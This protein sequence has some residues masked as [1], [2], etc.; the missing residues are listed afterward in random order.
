MDLLISEATC[1]WQESTHLN[2]RLYRCQGNQQSTCEP[3]LGTGKT[4]SP[5]AR[6]HSPL[7]F[8]LL[9]LRIECKE[10]AGGVEGADG[11]THKNIGGDDPAHIE[12]CKGE[13]L[14]HI[15]GAACKFTEEEHSSVTQ[16][17]ICLC[18]S[19]VTRAMTIE[20]SQR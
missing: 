7:G 1:T 20:Y 11:A 9:F 14:E 4:R 2:S 8:Y 18:F 13:V 3:P 10:K 19:T 6:S 5:H 15:H 16:C 17:R 12:V